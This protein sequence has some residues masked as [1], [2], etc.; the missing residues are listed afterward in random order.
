[1][2][3]EDCLEGPEPDEILGA[4]R[5]AQECQA[6]GPGAAAHENGLRWFGMVV[7]QRRVPQMNDRKGVQG[8]GFIQSDE[9]VVVSCP[10]G[11]LALNVVRVLSAH[12]LS[13]RRSLFRRLGADLGEFR[14]EGLRFSHPQQF[15]FELFQIAKYTRR[16]GLHLNPG[17][18]AGLGH[19]VPFGFPV[20]QKA[21]AHHQQGIGSADAITAVPQNAAEQRIAVYPPSPEAPRE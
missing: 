8:R 1:V 16:K 18:L 20:C 2:G 5:A 3:K 6:A 11:G 12:S 17:L 9:D 21:G 4:E 7:F 14:P 10:G 19:Q 15:V 13:G